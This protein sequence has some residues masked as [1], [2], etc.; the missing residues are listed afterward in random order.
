MVQIDTT[1]L[2]I[3]MLPCLI[4]LRVCNCAILTVLFAE[5]IENEMKNLPWFPQKI[6]DLDRCADNVLM[7]GEELDAEHPVSEQTERISSSDVRKGK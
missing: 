6:S 2:L 5:T 7:Y 3:N 4:D 1:S